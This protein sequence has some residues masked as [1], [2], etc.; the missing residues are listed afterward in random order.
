MNG[1]YLVLS[2]IIIVVCMG[3]AY[4]VYNRRDLYI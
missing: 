2:L 1:T 3:L 4:L